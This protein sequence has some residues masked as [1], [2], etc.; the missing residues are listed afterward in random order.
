MKK[1]QIARKNMLV[2]IREF[3][4]VHQAA[5]AADSIGGRALVTVAEVL[6]EIDAHSGT[7]RGARGEGQPAR[8]SARQVLA[9]RLDA[10]T[11]TARAIGQT[12][13]GFD[14]PFRLSRPATD[15]VLLT[16]ATVFAVDAEPAKA[17]F[18]ARG[19]PATFIDGIRTAADE[20]RQA[21]A[22]CNASLRQRTAARIGIDEALAR[23]DVAVRELDAVVT[24][25][26]A[27]DPATVGVWQSL[28]RVPRPRRTARSGQGGQGQGQG[29]GGQGGA[30]T[31]TGKEV[32]PHPLAAMEAEEQT[33][34]PATSDQSSSDSH[35]DDAQSEDAA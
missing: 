24:N 16:S 28:R 34:A 6:G 19:L 22:V 23:G 9:S 18:V 15:H 33:A 7:Q 21:I 11:R 32:T 17:Q 1:S 29:S 27:G 10:V 25:Q 26:F 5:F 30:V 2:R 4:E 31:P 14:Q 12:T 8:K 13:P 20:L 35:S 3:G